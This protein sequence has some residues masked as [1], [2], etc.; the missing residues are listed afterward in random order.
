M[1]SKISPKQG[2]IWLFDPDPVKGREI[3][4]KI[5]PALVVS[6]NALNGGPSELVIL[7]PCT[8]KEK[9]I[10]SHVR[11]DPL[12]GG[13]SIPTFAM[14]EQIR[15]V[16]KDRLIKKI[17]RIENERIMDNVHSWLIDFLWLEP[18]FLQ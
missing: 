15:A 4:K 12:E 7:V 6:C 14:C 8:S 2:E 17:G 16:S 9:G 18:T 10:D 13:V 5:R 3:G 1:G 11:I